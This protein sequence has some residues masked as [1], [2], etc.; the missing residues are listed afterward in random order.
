MT[1]VV[2]DRCITDRN[3]DVYVLDKN[4][5]RHLE[6]RCASTRRTILDTLYRYGR[7]HS[8]PSLS[9]V[10]ILI[11]MYLREL[12]LDADD[13]KWPDRDRFILSK[14]HGALGLSLIHISEPT[15]LKTRSRMPSSA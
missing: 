14:G 4:E 11:T 1:H 3:G 5:V 6:Y 8:G 2:T 7:G 12:R 10:E 9:L 15:R 13:P